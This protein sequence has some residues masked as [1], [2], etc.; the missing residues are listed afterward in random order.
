MSAGKR[1]SETMPAIAFFDLDRTLIRVN[2]ARAWMD[3]ERRAG[4]LGKRAVA[5]GLWWFA[6]YRLGRAG[7][8]DAVRAAVATLRGQCVTTFDARTQAFWEEDIAPTIRPGARRVLAAHR[9]AGDRLVLLTASSQQLGRAAAGALELDEVLSN[10][11]EEEDGCFT[12]RAQ[13]PLCYGDG[14]LHHAEACARRHGVQLRDCAFYTDSISDRLVLE[15]VG[16]PVCIDPDRRLRRLARR[17]GWEI[18]DW[19]RDGSTD[20]ERGAL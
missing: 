12:G 8:D 1:P 19:D 11:F 10:V 20:A 6:M 13:E 14:K 5:Q 17:R 4:R 18:E 3:H 16:R 7:L 9:E 2:S 15:A